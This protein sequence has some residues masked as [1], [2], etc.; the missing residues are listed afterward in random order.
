MSKPYIIGVTGTYGKSSCAYLLYKYFKSLDYS[1]CLL[2]SIRIDFP[3]E[4]ED[5]PFEHVISSAAEL[6]EYL[7]S[8][9]DEEADFVILECNAQ[10]IINHV[11]DTVEFDCKI[12][13]TFYNNVEMHMD[14]QQYLNAKVS[15]M[16]DLCL[17][18]INCD[19]DDYESFYKDNNTFL[20]GI[21]IDNPVGYISP[22]IPMPDLYPILKVG[23]Y[24]Q[25]YCRYNLQGDELEFYTDLPTFTNLYNILTCVAALHAIHMYDD[26]SF[27]QQFVTYEDDTIPGRCELIDYNGAKIIIDSNNSEFLARAINDYQ[28]YLMAKN[29][30]YNIKGEEF[31]SWEPL[32][33][34]GI[35]NIIGG[36]NTVVKE[37]LKND[38]NF[39][40]IN[41]TMNMNRDQYREFI[42]NLWA[43]CH[44]TNSVPDGVLYDA[45]RDLSSYLICD[46]TND[47]Y[48]T[49]EEL[50]LIETRLEHT[51][52]LVYLDAIAPFNCNYW[53]SIVIHNACY[54]LY[55]DLFTRISEHFKSFNN[56]QLTYACNYVNDIV[57][58]KITAYG[59]SVERINAYTQYF[60][61]LYVTSNNPSS[62]GMN[63]EFVMTAR[64][65]NTKTYQNI[66]RT[67]TIYTILNE[68]Q[69]G[70]LILITGRGNRKSL[71]KG[72]WIN[73]YISDKEIIEQYVADQG[74]ENVSTRN[75]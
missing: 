38:K 52:N 40:F 39:N 12:L 74:D 9:Y 25:S 57:T 32:Q 16:N 24:T 7:Q 20:Y 35:F 26:D 13:T 62:E 71:Y 4:W 11:F 10:A 43:M 54:S 15:F 51:W 58:A 49:E 56:E 1:T 33:F 31:Q 68:A 47:D 17:K 64:A 34:K 67:E 48:F 3:I 59:R 2:S 65:L 5:K 53:N 66:N 23:G 50:Q 29:E 44:H 63:F 69:S 36:L 55:Y 18:V 61:K 42:C 37:E 19:V 30:Y 46:F 41:P 60:N 22:I 70:D 21:G 28:K 75:L 6:W 72:E 8:A 27:T 73:E 45:G 14:P